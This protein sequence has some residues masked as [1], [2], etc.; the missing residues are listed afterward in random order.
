[1]TTYGATIRQIRLN[2]GYSQ[3]EIYTGIVSK[4]YA[5]EFEKGKHDMS[6]SHFT[7]VL[8]RLSLKFQEFA[9]IHN[10]YQE[11]VFSKTM[12]RFADAANRGNRKDLQAIEK[13]LGQSTSETDS[14]IAA[15]A[16]LTLY[17]LD[18]PAD[19]QPADYPPEDVK[20]LQDYLMAS[21]SWT[22]HEITFFIN[23]SGFFD[24]EVRCH[25]MQIVT[26]RIKKYHGFSF[27]DKL[28][29]T[30]IVNFLGDAFILGDRQQI[31]LYLDILDE[32][33][34]DVTLAFQRDFYLFYTGLKDLLW[35]DSSLGEERCRYIIRHLEIQGHQYFATNL[36]QL[37]ALILAK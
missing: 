21:N 23:C 25:L 12:A 8:D 5:I 4:S 31:S 32:L 17:T 11:P 9:F 28:F 3:K 19:Y 18:H 13:E 6:I 7:A 35:G 14:L 10:D 20:L 30:M 34:Q 33:T 36:D 16:R 29:S 26:K 1:M 24:Y 2:K 15:L 22:F 27:Y 37:L